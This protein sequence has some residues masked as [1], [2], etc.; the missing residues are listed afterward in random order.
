MQPLAP[1]GTVVEDVRG[2][3]QHRDL[4][5]VPRLLDLARPLR[6]RPLV[7]GG[8]AY[9]VDQDVHGGG[10]EGGVGGVHDQ[11]VEVRE[12]RLE[13]GA[14]GAPHRFSGPIGA[15]NL[16]QVNAGIGMV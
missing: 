1:L 6:H 4:R 7:L 14:E 9:V 2:P 12:E 15:E 13:G 8:A 10:L 5:P 16:P 3:L 11:Q